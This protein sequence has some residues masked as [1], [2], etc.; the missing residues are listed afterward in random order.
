MN[1]FATCPKGLEYLLRDELAALG[2]TDARESL[3]GVHFQGG[4]AIAYRALLWSRLASRILMPIAQFDAPDGEALYE[5]VAA[6]DFA[7]LFGATASFAVDANGSTK[8]ITHTHY[9]LQ[10]VKDA[11]V[12]QFRRSTGE[13]PA[14]DTERPDVRLN[15]LLRRERGTLSLDL[16]G[17][18]LHQRGWRD[19]HGKASLKENL[20]SAMLVRA[21]WPRIAAEGGALVDPMCGSGTLLIEGAWM[22][23]DVAPSWKREYYAVAGWLGHDALLWKTLRDEVEQRARDGLSKLDARF[24]G[25]DQDASVLNDARH[26][27]Q[28]AGVAGFVHLGRQSVSHLKRPQECER[29]GLVIVNPPYGQRLGE[30]D[31]LV[32]LYRELGEKL[33][34]EFS[35]W[36][37]SVITSEA[38]LGRAIKLRAEK[39]YALYNGAIECQ[40]LNFDLSV[41]ETAEPRV[42]KPLSA[43]AE[44]LKNRI[45][46]NRK[47]LRKRVERDK[48]ECYRLYDADLPEYAAAIDVYGDHLHI[49]EYQAPSSIPE[50]TALTRWREV[51]RVAGETLGVPREKIA[52]KQRYRAKGGEKYGRMDQRGEL[53]EVEEGGL[54]FLVNLFDYLD[55]GLF[56]DHRPLRARVR[57]LAQGKR[58]LNLFCYTGSVS[59]Y[60]AAGG[61]ATTTSVDLS[62][63]YLEWASSNLALNGY[64]G[65]SHR[66]VQGDAQ[67]F[68]DENRGSYDLIFVD[69]PTFSNSKRAEDFDVQRDHVRLL[70]ACA[71]RL[72]PG[73]LILFSNNFRRFVL[74]TAALSSLA[75]K[76][77]S[78]STIPFD[79]ERDPKIHRAW[80]LRHATPA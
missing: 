53:L 15:L 62:K 11:V 72:A 65:S 48:V 49:Q 34:S 19:G 3:A 59:V 7:A 75:I 61:A 60:A 14:I 20:A 1:F 67:A 55:T 74:D 57:E 43:G 33:A 71:Q 39:K 79:F 80:E 36:R 50:A 18:P 54:R 29:P 23:A 78:A 26:N 73:G 22:A 44:M 24:F 51:V 4:L 13:R 28:R 58:F 27:A 52:L 32:P 68:V 40:L 30:R 17:A 9:A 12:D 2:A 41:Q 31:A 35:G 45:E 56:L 25:F 5:G 70:L 47:H 6:V 64:I 69:P 10:R 66:L 8:G 16:S 46:K 42:P 37:A 63:T 76:D 38:D 77:I 21:Q